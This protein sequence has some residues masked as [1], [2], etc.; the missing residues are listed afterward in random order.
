M[1]CCKRYACY[2]RRVRGQGLPG[3][4][5]PVWEG[6][7]VMRLLDA[8]HGTPPAL[9]T[10]VKV[11]YDDVRRVLFFGFWAQDDA[12]VSDFRRRDEPIYE[13]DVLEVFLCDASPPH[14]YKELQVSPLNVQYDADITYTDS[15]RIDINVGW[16]LAGWRT[17]TRF[18]P[19]ARSLV[20]VWAVPASSLRDIPEPGQS[21]RMNVYRCDHSPAGVALQAWS[22]TGAREFHRPECFGWI[23]FVGD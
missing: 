2:F 6:L 22:P 11:F 8:E 13:Q 10:E 5:E 17:R 20:S 21:W 7:P 18:D 3:E 4:D 14:R 12:V 19:A 16:D 1:A 23:D 9:A 15:E